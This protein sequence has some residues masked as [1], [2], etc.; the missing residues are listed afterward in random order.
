M[1]KQRKVI[2]NKPKPKR[3]VIINKRNNS[4]I[5]KNKI[6]ERF[7]KITQTLSSPKIIQKNKV[8]RIVK[9]KK[10]KKI[11]ENNNHGKN[12]ISKVFSIFF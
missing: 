5:E 3:T 2:I 1:V 6:N 11:K 9:I 7:K 4:K 8:K 10:N 12:V